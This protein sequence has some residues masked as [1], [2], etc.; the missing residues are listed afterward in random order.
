MKSYKYLIIGNSAGGMGAMEAIRGIDRDGSM[1]VISDEEHH[2]YGRP[3]ISYYLAD[4]IGYDKI[5]YRPLDFYEKNNI[6][7]ILGKKVVDI[8]F[9]RFSTPNTPGVLKV[10]NQLLFLVV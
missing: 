8:D 4:E 7:A 1:A 9:F 10:A 2:V 5:F 3:L 6:D